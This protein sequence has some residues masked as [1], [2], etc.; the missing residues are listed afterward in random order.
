ME[1]LS[2][3]LVDKSIEAFLMGMEVYNK[4]TIR[5]RIEGF[6]FFII[7]AWELMLK[8]E[9]V[10][11][12]ESIYYKDNPDRTLS[13]NETINKIYSDK[14]TRIRLNLEKI[15][16]LR[17]ISTHFITEDYE[18]KYAPL[19]QACVLNFV[20]EIK[21]F[22]DA[23]ITNYISQNFLTVSAS[24]EPLTNEQIKLKY[25]PEIAEKFI[26]QANEIDV[27]SHEYSSEKFAINIKQSL[28]ITKK[29][30]EADFF[31]SIN[32]ESKNEVALVKELK[33]P[34]DTHKYSYTNVITAVSER[35]K[36]KQ[37]KLSYPPGFNQHVLNL[38]IDFYNIKDDK[39]YAYKHTIGNQ[40][41]HT[42]SQQFIDFIIVEI[43]KDPINF[44]NSLKRK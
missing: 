19:F 26:K 10:N 4:P 35:L 27:L 15:V 40:T 1:N 12:N 21:R 22:H 41:H 9:L 29:K 44:V 16:E 25:P 33:D 38:I 31:V 24:Y 2:Q 23:E 6:S 18:A 17:N 42:Y 8:A 20:N 7:N 14:N 32:K 39:K 5:Y 3:R 34:S 28:Y 30:S 37:I 43:E 36:K 13:V 11:R